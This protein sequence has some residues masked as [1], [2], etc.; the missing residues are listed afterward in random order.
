MKSFFDAIARRYDRDYA[1]SGA[2]SRERLARMLDAIANRRRVLSLGLGTGR[3]LPALLDAGHEVHGIEV[4]EAMIDECNKRA[5]TVPIVRGDFYDPLPFADASFDAVIALHGTLAHPPRE[6]AHR[7]LAFEIARVLRHGGV[8]Y[9][10]VPAAEGLARLGVGVT[11]P[12]SFVHRDEA[13]GIEITGVARTADEW[14]DAFPRL[15][16]RTA[17]LGEVEHAVVGTKE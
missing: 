10:E 7:L 3:E 1:L 16:V 2:T 9:A 13:S 4:S 5:R 12:R 6:G 8:F 17:P 14:K 15:A 11:G